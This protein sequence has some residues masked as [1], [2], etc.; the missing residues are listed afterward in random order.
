MKKINKKFLILVMVLIAL[1]V[2][3]GCQSNVDEN[4]IT[5]ADRIIYLS[6]TWSS[7]MDDGFLTALLVWPLAQLINL[8]YSW[9][10]SSAASIIVV[11]LLFALITLPLS[12]KSTVST[13]KLQMIQ[14]QLNAIQAKYEG[15]TDDNSKMRQAQEMQALYNKNN[16]SPMGSLLMPFIQFP[17]LIAMYYAVQR[18]DAV[19]SGTVFGLPLSTTP[20]TAFSNF[21]T[22]WPLVII[23]VLMIIAQFCSS[24]VPGWLAKWSRRKQKDYRAYKEKKDPNAGQQSIMTVVMVG[25]VAMIGFSWPIAM[26][27]YWLINSVINSLKTIFIQ[28][29]YVNHA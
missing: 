4:G 22:M 3:T 5:K 14:P 21:S 2:L 11:S 1:V 7:A 27:I 15:K 9:I 28:V 29:R 17:V 19:V 6:T 20:K 13:Q 10:G 12:I 23:F 24:K 16:I 18:A 25:M 8:V 26:S